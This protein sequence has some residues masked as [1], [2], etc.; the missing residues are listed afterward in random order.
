MGNS[1]DVSKSGSP[2]TYLILALAVGGGAYYYHRYGHSTGRLSPGESSYTVAHDVRLADYVRRL[3]SGSF[4]HLSLNA[5][6]QAVCSAFAVTVAIDGSE[7][8][9]GKI[10]Q[11]HSVF[12][13]DGLKEYRVSWKPPRGSQKRQFRAL[14]G[15]PAGY[16]SCET[17]IDYLSVRR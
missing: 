15:V 8:A 5:L 12:R 10:P 3:P 9:S 2:L 14:V 16:T 11:F 4:D 1:G 17:I 13:G 6:D 7:V